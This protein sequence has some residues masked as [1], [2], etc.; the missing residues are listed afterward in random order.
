VALAVNVGHVRAEKHAWQVDG[1][2]G[3]SLAK[4]FA[5]LYI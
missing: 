5:L 3:L 1:S 4:R 2:K